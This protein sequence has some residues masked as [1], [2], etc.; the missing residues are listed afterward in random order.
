[1]ILV[2]R[3]EDRRTSLFLQALAGSGVPAREFRLGELSPSMCAQMLK[4]IVGQGDR[5]MARAVF[6]QTLGNAAMTEMAAEAIL[7][8]SKDPNSFLPRAIR[9]RL[10]RLS[11]PAAS[12]FQFLLTQQDPVD[13][14][15]AGKAREL[16]EIDEPLRA[17]RRERLLRVRKTG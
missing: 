4:S 16:F 2:Y 12:L 8:G 9:P 7:E 1:V 6:R 14:S 5:R 17:L 10:R 3:T 15:V 11:S 13:A